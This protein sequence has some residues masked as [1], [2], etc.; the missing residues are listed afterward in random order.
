MNPDFLRTTMLDWMRNRRFSVEDAR[1]ELIRGMGLS[2]TT[3]L[4]DVVAQIRAEGRKNQI[5]DVP[6]GVHATEYSKALTADVQESAW[7][8]GPRP[9]DRYW[10]ALRQRLEASSLAAVVD[11]IDIASTKVVA[12]FADPGIRRLKKKG[13]VVGYVQS[14][15]TANYTAVMAKAADAGYRLFIVLSGM[16][17]NL[18]KQTQVRINT[19]L[20][21]S[22]WAPLTTADADFGS[23]MNGSALMAEGVRCIAVVKKNASRLKRL[24]E[25][26][27][28]VDE[29]VRARTPVL[30]LDDEADQA[31]PNSLAAR[32]E[33]SK[34]NALLREIWQE[35]PTGSYVG[36]TATPFANVFMDPNDEQELYPSDFILDLPRPA[37]YFGAERIFGRTALE[38]AD[39]PD[40]GLDM[41]RPVA[42]EEAASLKPPS[43]KGARELFDP[44]LPDSLIDAIRWFVLA[45]AIRRHRGQGGLHSSML[46]HTTS[47]VSPH[48]VMRDRVQ[49]LLLDW[50]RNL[51][52]R[53]LSAFQATFDREARRVTGLNEESTPAWEA[54]ASTLPSV[55]SDVRVV[56][57]NGSSDDRLD[58]GRVDADGNPIT[59]T[60]IAIGGGT[61][62]RGL[63]LEG[64]MVSYFTRTAATYD[65]LLQM[66]R[67]FGY[68]P[69]YEDLPR[70][71]MTRDL[72]EDFEF[73]SLVEEE[74]RQ[75]MHRLEF[76]A[77]T[78]REM[79]LRIRAHP[80]RL[81]ITAAGKMFHAD[82][83]Q[84]SYAG[85]RHQTIV[86]HERETDLLRANIELTREFLAYCGSSAERGI[87][88]PA[89]TQFFDIPAGKIVG[90]LSDFKFHPEQPGLR[91]DHIVGWINRAAAASR[92]NVVVIGNSKRHRDIDGNPVELGEL[93]LGLELPLPL[94]N[95]APLAAVGHCANIKAL[96]SQQDWVA[97]FDPALVAETKPRSQSFQDFRR[98]EGGSSGLLIVY[99]VSPHSVPLRATQRT[100]RRPMRAEVPIIGLGLVFPDADSGF[101]GRDGAYYAVKPDWTPITDEELDLPVDREGSVRLD[102][103]DIVRGDESD[104]RR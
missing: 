83:V 51:D 22:R 89:R 44:E 42:D 49:D 17:N 7:Y 80:G 65:T 29:E 5:L 87:S 1:R 69:G 41:V 2:D 28:D 93:D 71:W 35:V 84:L 74:I 72:R 20:G 37:A 52:H 90:Y 4:D 60:V 55:I 3:V 13:L 27:R 15:K 79:G 103:N 61:L 96:L 48:F 45:V 53:E 50:D 47:Y 54:V 68:R 78:P 30:I 23:V 62:S 75:D 91:G 18:R 16:H 73:L 98:Q 38:D 56:V 64:L 34:I 85:Q 66:G 104:E 6:S 43:D 58:Y 100:S 57:D 81:A 97:D 92:W 102:G 36:Y 95:R 14:G 33:L 8:T 26:L 11:D 88:S 70:I 94:V 46:I 24:R 32:E 67:W 63:T 21:I 10:P 19:D 9:E 39:D 40:P 86:L 101:E 77:V 12:H 76:M 59:E 82:V 99:G 25:W 31:T